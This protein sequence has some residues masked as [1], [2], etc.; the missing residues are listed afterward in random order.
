MDLTQ[1]VE[2]PRRLAPIQ[3]SIKFVFFIFRLLLNLS[4]QYWCIRVFQLLDLKRLNFCQ[5][6]QLAAKGLLVCICGT[7]TAP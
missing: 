5:A 3:V 6:T 7:G 2:A 1:L 4:L